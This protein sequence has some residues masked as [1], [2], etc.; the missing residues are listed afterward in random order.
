[1]VRNALKDLEK[2][3]GKQYIFVSTTSPTAYKD[4]EA[5]KS[6]TETIKTE[7]EGLIKDEL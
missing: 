5:V 2:V 4:V 7:I 1:M 3:T 6:L